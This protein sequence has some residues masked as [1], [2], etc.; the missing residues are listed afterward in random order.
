[1]ALIL[2]WMD[3]RHLKISIESKIVQ[4]GLR[5]RKLWPREVDMKNQEWQLRQEQ[6]KLRCDTFKSQ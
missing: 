3:F 2:A 6:A 5:M 1:M 4:F